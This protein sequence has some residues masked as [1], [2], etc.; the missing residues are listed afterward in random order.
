MVITA[1]NDG[2]ERK[3]FVRQSHRTSTKAECLTEATD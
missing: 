1:L 3:N 2:N